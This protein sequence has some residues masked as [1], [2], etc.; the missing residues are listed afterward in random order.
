M[1]SSG[2]RKE[3]ACPRSPRR[4][5]QP[6]CSGS[7]RRT[8]RNRGVSGGPRM[9]APVVCGREYG[10]YSKY[11]SKLLWSCNLNVYIVR[12]TF[13]KMLPGPPVENGRGQSGDW[14]TK[15]S[16]RYSQVVP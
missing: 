14:G 1:Y 15:H 12:F 13:S 11:K 10:C 6:G 4:P 5:G 8:R 7:S 2:D 16:A 3:V 9:A